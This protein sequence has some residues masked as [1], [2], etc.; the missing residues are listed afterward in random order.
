MVASHLKF[1]ECSSHIGPND[2]ISGIGANKVGI[3]EILYGICFSYYS[4]NSLMTNA[5]NTTEPN[6]K[7]KPVLVCLFW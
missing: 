7:G 4:R 5:N 6:K 2:L 1:H 3:R